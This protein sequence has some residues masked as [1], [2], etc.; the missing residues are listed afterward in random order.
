MISNG[1][2]L[3][4]ITE[5][6]AADIRRIDRVDDFGY[7]PVSG[8]FIDSINPVQ[9][10][11]MIKD[12]YYMWIK[13]PL[14]N[15]IIESFLDFV[16]GDG[17]QFKANDEKAQEVLNTFYYDSDNNWDRFG[18][19]RFRDL[20][21]YGELI[22]KTEKTAMTGRLKTHSI[23]PGRISELLRNKK[24]NEQLSAIMFTNDDRKYK[25]IRGYEVNDGKKFEGDVFYWKIN[26]TTHQ[27]RGL[28]DLFVSR[29]WLRLYD[30]ALYST[31]ERVGLLLSFVWDITIDNANDRTLK[32]KIKRIKMN[33]PQPGGVRVHNEKEKWEALSPSLQGK[34]LENL[35]RLFKSPV[36]AQTRTPEHFLGLGGDV[37]YATALSMNA[38]FYRKIKGRQKDIIYIYQDMF[39]YAI[40]CANQ[41]NMLEGVEDFGYDVMLPEPDKEV[42]KNISD[43]L[44]KF[45]RALTVLASNGYIEHVEVKKILQL[46]VGQLGVDLE[47][48]ETEEEIEESLYNKTAKYVKKI[49]EK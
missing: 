48:E 25:I 1:L 7:S 8:T 49:K 33:P 13:N 40:Y 43:T 12:S 38:P 35:F 22:L 3:K 10:D 26:S 9:Q 5:T 27:T 23:Y 4:R 39:D 17:I 42:A 34:D 19:G 31:L 28:S 41:A 18:K 30:K 44:E 37:N 21:L 2:A 11:Y 45:S 46:I 6:T 15:A 20:S 16:L 32:E 29:D 36:L 47:T 14:A 24:N